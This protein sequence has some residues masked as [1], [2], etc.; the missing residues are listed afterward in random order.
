MLLGFIDFILQIRIVSTNNRVRKHSDQVSTARF[1]KG[2]HMKTCAVKVEAKASAMTDW[3][4]YC[5]NN[6]VVIVYV[7]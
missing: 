2:N 7:I 3:D 5:Y 1:A 6:I 4:P